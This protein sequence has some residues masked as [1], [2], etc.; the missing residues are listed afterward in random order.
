MAFW[1]P[2]TTAP[3]SSLDRDTENETGEAVVAHAE[4]QYRHL[5]LQQQ[6]ERLPVFKLRRTLLYLVEKYQTTIVVGQTGC[7]KTTQIPQYLN[8]AG[9]AVNGKQI[10]CTQPRRIAATSVAQRVAEE[11]N[12]PLGSQVGYLIRF[13]DQ[14][15]SDTKIKY[16]TDGMLFRETMIDPLLTNY[17]VIM[18]DEAHERSLYTDIL[19]GVIKK[20]QKKRS[21]L[22]VIISSATMDAE[23]FY[24][25]FNHN[26]SKDRS[27]DTA[28]IVSLEGRMFPV[29]ILYAEKPVVDYM[30]TAIQTVFDIHTKEPAGDILV[31]L[32]GREEIDTV[33]SE[34][35]ERGKTLP[36]NSLAVMPLP[37]YAGLTI[38]EQLQVFE[39]APKYTRKIIV[40][41]NIA[42]A[43]VTLEGIVY[44][45]DTG[46]VKV[47]AYNPKTGMEAL[48][49]TP[50]SKASALQRAGRAGRVKAGKA[51]RLYTEETYRGLRDTSI[52]E[53]QR[54][55]LAPVILQLK[56][57]GIDNVLRFDFITPPP[58]ELMI[59]ALEL[60]Y[61]LN[62]LDQVGR[63]TIPLGMQLAEFPVDPMLGKILLASKEFGCSHEIVTIAAMMSV[64]NIFIQPAKVPKEVMHEARR[65]FWVEEG[66]TLTLVNVYNAFINKGNKSGKWCH[67]RFLNFKALSRA[68][69]IRLQLMKYL[70]RFEIPLMSATSKYP[71]TEEGRLAASQDVRKCITSGYFSQAAIAEPD[72]SG[73][74]RTVRDNVILHIHPNSVLFNRNPKCVVFHEVIE[75]TQAYMRDLTVI[76]PEWLAELAPHFYEYKK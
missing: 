36:Q 16:M 17:S 73:R 10:A 56:A 41:T 4:K 54:S 40:S 7:G 27:K 43:S 61:S 68:M 53:I 20:I 8:E 76:E 6:R 18:I 55:N 2:G 38:E 51:F 62:A 52:P 59:R 44:V 11:M 15:N 13:D 32:T 29:D 39:S 50:V 9:W 64:Q 33:V 71:K 63:L 22:R 46:F 30:E 1:K 65:K 24:K 74:F 34:I 47:R 70:K 45:I 31:F 49:V 23:Q 35:Y 25:F 66:D 75:T 67:D 5:T 26:A 12:C 21:D 69:T 72:G 14:T 28:T 37:L 19:I 48:V 42:E 3:G 60:L 57:L 58:A